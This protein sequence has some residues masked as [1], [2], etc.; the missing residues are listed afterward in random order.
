MKS[1]PAG[2]TSSQGRGRQPILFTEPFVTTPKSYHLTGFATS[3]TGLESLVSARGFRRS[4]PM[5]TDS[6]PPV[7]DVWTTTL[8]PV[9]GPSPNGEGQQER[10]TRFRN[11]ETVYEDAQWKNPGRA[12]V[13][14]IAGQRHPATGDVHR[15]VTASTLLRASGGPAC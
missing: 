5:S 8:G 14:R 6:S 7:P 11:G 15:A 4:L 1:A 3:P 13:A 9:A 12:T 2:V 10:I